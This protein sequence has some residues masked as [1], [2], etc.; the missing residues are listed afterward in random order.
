MIQFIF[1]RFPQRTMKM[2]VVYLIEVDEIRLYF[3]R[4]KNIKRPSSVFF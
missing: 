1:H 3:K 4:S 2:V